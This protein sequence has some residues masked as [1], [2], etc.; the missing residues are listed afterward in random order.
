MVI[1]VVA[2]AE[3]D[4]GDEPAVAA[5]VLR[6]VRLRADHVTER[7][8]G[9]G[10]I[11]YKYRAQHSGEEETTKAAGEAAVQVSGDKRQEKPGGNDRPVVSVLLN[12]CNCLQLELW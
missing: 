8:D 7:V 3:T 6:A 10:G 12:K 4:E 2:L 5:A 9:E 11:E 1:V